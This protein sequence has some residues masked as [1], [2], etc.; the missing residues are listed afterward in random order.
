MILKKENISSLPV[1]IE[2]WMAYSFKIPDKF[3]FIGMCGKA[4]VLAQEYGPCISIHPENNN[5][6]RD[7][8]MSTSYEECCVRMRERCLQTIDHFNNHQLKNNPIL[9]NQNISYPF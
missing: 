8:N 4:M 3:I 2:I 1:G 9:V 5:D 6:V 7:G